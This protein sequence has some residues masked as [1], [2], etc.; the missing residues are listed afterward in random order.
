[1][2]WFKVPKKIYFEANSIRYLETMSDVNRVMIVTDKGMSQLGYVQKIV[3]VLNRRQS[4]VV[5][6]IFD[7]VEPDPSIQT[8]DAGAKVMLDFKPDTII[9]LG[10]G[11]PMDAAKV[12]WLKYEH[13]EVNFDDLK[14]K[15]IDIRKR[16]IK[17]PELGHKASLV[18]IPTTSGTGSEVTPFAVISDPTVNKKYPLADYALTPSV[19]IIDGELAKS[20]PPHIAADTGMD[21]LTHAIESYVSVLASDFTDGLALQAIR[22]VFDYLPR[23]VKNGASDFEAKE[24]MHNAATIAGMAFGNAFLGINHSLAHKIGGL[25]HV[26]HGRANAILLPY[27]IMYNGTQPSKLSTW[28]KYTHYQA[29]QKYQQVAR[30]LGL[31]GKT[32]ESGVKAL[33]T[34]TFEL[35]KSLNIP[36]SFK[37]T[38]IDREAFMSQLEFLAFNAYEDQCSPANPRQ[39]LVEDLKKILIDAYEGNAF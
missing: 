6:E 16:S 25:F 28:P 37:E 1:M 14:Q 39:P 9:A 4:A 36:T 24:K 11:S 12:M 26:P 29:D 5:I 34:A 32:T 2:Q 17:Y 22:L 7:Q 27:V 30:T 21:V 10:G 38:G 15:F 23:S 19:A 18:C 8:V 20:L 13:P 33:A 31:D 35:S 3:D